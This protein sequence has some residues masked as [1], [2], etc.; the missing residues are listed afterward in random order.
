MVKHQI[1]VFICT[2]YFFQVIQ[3]MFEI[4]ISLVEVKHLMGK[5]DKINKYISWESRN[6]T[7]HKLP[8]FLIF[9]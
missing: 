2:F 7:E 5:I 8:I 6:Q 1:K 9:R 4:L 3:I